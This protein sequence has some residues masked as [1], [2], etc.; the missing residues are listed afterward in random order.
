MKRMGIIFHRFVTIFCPWIWVI[1]E[2]GGG[3]AINSSNPPES[4]D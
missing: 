1:S 3:G 4:I 2:V